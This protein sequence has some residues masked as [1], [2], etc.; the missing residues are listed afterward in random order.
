MGIHRVLMGEMGIYL[1]SIK[2]QPYIT[3]Q[4]KVT[5]KS[6]EPL[7]IKLQEENLCKSL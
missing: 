1:S 3:P 5:Q 4:R 7:T 6:K 2:T